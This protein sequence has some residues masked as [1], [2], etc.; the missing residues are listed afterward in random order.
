MI[1][2]MS[3]HVRPTEPM[4]PTTHKTIVGAAAPSIAMNNAVGSIRSVA[5]RRR[6]RRPE[7]KRETHHRRRPRR[8]DRQGWR[9]RRRPLPTGSWRQQG[10]H[11]HH[12]KERELEEAEARHH[13]PAP[14]S[15]AELAP[16]FVQLVQDPGSL[17]PPRGANDHLQTQQR[18]DEE[19]GGVDC[20][21][22]SRDS[23]QRRS[24]RRAPAP[25]RGWPS[26]SGRRAHSPPAGA[27]G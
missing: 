19:R 27:V 3:P 17:G 24:A 15:C 1:Q 2:M 20:Q 10:R 21:S 13:H 22:P 26:D 5:A 23:W 11:Q 14:G 6:A 16:P 7:S 12:R 8:S 9:P 18:G 4:K 25:P